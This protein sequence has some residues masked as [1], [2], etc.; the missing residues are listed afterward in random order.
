MG[1]EPLSPDLLLSLSKG[2]QLR[3]AAEIIRQ[4]GIVAFPTETFYGLAVDPFDRRAVARLFSVKERSPDKPVLVLVNNLD[5]LYRLV[6]EIPDLYQPLMGRHWPG[7][8][9]LIFPAVAQLPDLL[10]GNT[11]TVGVRISSHPLACALVEA[12][13]GPV[14][15]TSANLSGQPAAGDVE[16]VRRQLGDRID[17]LLD[18]GPTKGGSGSTI[19][20]LAAGH[21]TLI[22]AGAVTFP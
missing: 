10:T 15:A 1:N 20:G 9:T 8:L 17:Y 18:G 11:G 5:Q 4:R 13:G 12:V 19:V 7:P 14:T 3:R 22:R 2:P 16:E 6:T 21:L